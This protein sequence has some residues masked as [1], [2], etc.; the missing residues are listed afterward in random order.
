MTDFSDGPSLELKPDATLSGSKI[1]RCESKSYVFS[2]VNYYWDGNDV[3]VP[4]ES[5]S[6]GVKKL[7]RFDSFNVTVG[8]F[9]S[10]FA[11]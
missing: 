7:P 11:V 9:H 4:K 1:L 10:S 6:Q 2:G 5:C 3:L 8:A